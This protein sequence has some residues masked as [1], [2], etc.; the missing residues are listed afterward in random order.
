MI[1]FQI[2]RPLAQRRHHHGNEK[3]GARRMAWAEDGMEAPAE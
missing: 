1:S 3:L 2:H